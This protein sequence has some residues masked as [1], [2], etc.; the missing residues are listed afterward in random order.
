MTIELRP[1]QE[2]FVADLR[3]AYAKGARALLG[4]APTGSG[5]TVMF[6]YMA[7]E[8][9][10][11]GRRVGVMAHRIELLDQIGATLHDFD[12]PHGFVSPGR[13]PD[14]FAPVQVCSVFSVARRI[15][16]Y[17]RRPFDFLIVDEA[18][19]AAGGSTWHQVI[20]VHR[21]ARV[22]GVTATPMRLSGEPVA[23]AFDAMVVGPTTGELIEL[24]ALARYRAF[25][26]TTPELDGVHRR[27]G[28]FVRPELDTAMDRPTITGDAVTH[29]LRLA[30]GKRA[31]AFCVSI[32]H[33]EH[34]AAQF[35][36]AGVSAASLDGHM[37]RG[38]RRE[39]IRRFVDG[40]TLVLTSCDLVSEG[41]DLPAIEAVILLRPT[42]S[43]ALHLQ[44]IGRG[45]RPYPGKET[46]LILDHAGNLMRHGLPDEP[47]EWTLQ[48]RG[49][50]AAKPGETA[51]PVRT[52]ASCFGVFR[53][54]PACPHCGAPVMV[55]GRRVEEIEGELAEVDIEVLRRA[56]RAEQGRAQTFEQLVALGRARGYRAPE[57]WARHMLAARARA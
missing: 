21:N 22:L 48:G 41:F 51:I 23:D 55:E 25:A 43:L 36:A 45:L 24:G 49:K 46:A 39:T 28:D 16:R 32:A 20:G 31:L 26:P 18:H 42:Q 29:Y 33:A 4:V 3:A 11:R 12:V 56:K 19:H 9:I 38:E 52:C 8:A 53:P 10:R 57:G 14:P 40:E 7:S 34:V 54:A 6:S 44:Q 5:K 1:Y 17:A 2:R 13:S 27:M 30:R 37:E 35:I 47:R 15:E 50:D